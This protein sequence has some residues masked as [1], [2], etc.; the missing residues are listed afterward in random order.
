MTSHKFARIEKDQN[1]Q[2]E[3]S[4]P[5]LFQIRFYQRSSVAN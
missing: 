5:Y 1:Q 2:K 4:G 3:V